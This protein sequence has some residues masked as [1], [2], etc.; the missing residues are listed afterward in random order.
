MT[1]RMPGIDRLV[2]R[3]GRE[4][5]RH[6]DHRRVRARLADGLGHR[7]EHRH[8]LDVLAALAGSDAGDDLRA[9]GA[10]PQPVEAALG[11]GQPLHHEPR[12]EIDDDRHQPLFLALNTR[13]G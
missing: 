3:V 4:A 13:Y 1:V 7:V 11:A 9:V 5:R 2:D 8:A 12:L 10:V 6:E